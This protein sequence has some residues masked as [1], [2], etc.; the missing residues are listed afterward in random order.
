MAF[1]AV[2]RLF[3]LAIFTCEF[4][5]FP[6][7]AQ[8]APAAAGNADLQLVVLLS[9]HGVR[10]PMNKPESYNQYS[11]LPWAQW[12]VPPSYLTAHG[13]QLMKIFGAWDRAEFSAAGLLAPTGCA[14]AQHI[15]ILAD[16]DERTRESG[17][18]LAEGMM[19]GC[20]VAVNSEPDGTKDQ[21]FNTS[22]SHPAATGAPVAAAAIAGRIGGNPNNLTELY[23]PQLAALD[24]ILAGC[25]HA[26]ADAK[27]TSLFEIPA[28]LAPGP[29]DPAVAFSGPAITGSGLA[30]NLLL[31]YTQGMSEADTGWG[32]LDGATL[33]LLMQLNAAQWDFSYRT[34][35][36]ARIHAANLLDHIAKTL[37]QGAAGKAVPGA[38]GKPGDRVVILVGHDTNIVTVAGAL[39]IGWVEDGMLN[40]TPPGGTLRF[41]LWRSRATGK[42]FVRL[43]YAAQT[44][45]QMRFA[46]PLTAA[47]P[48][49]EAPVFVPACSGADLSCSVERFSAAARQ[50]IDPVAV[51]R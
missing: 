48:P 10:S 34:P 6:L 38:L 19:P 36:I 23:R 27:R 15:T 40:E 21:L 43:V 45:E 31:E 5:G 37:E 44:L 25:G 47:N 33:R 24:R 28:N 41:E 32:C 39:G 9:R 2:P 22:I 18:A 8:T 50:V 30:A 29:A 16:N 51:Q 3:C 35:A 7:A 13:H 49:V 46:Q 17:Q 11:A 14:D 42:P 4:L 12:D 20:T 1:R 26:P